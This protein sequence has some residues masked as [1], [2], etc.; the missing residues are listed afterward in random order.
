M[1]KCAFCALPKAKLD[2]LIDVQESQAHELFVALAGGWELYDALP[3]LK[4]AQPGRCCHTSQAYKRLE[5]RSK[6]AGTLPCS[7]VCPNQPAFN[8]SR[9]KAEKLI[10]PRVLGVSGGRLHNLRKSYS[11]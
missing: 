2:A 9:L 4:D 10:N 3:P 5:M 6:S 8:R 7:K 1:R 11:R